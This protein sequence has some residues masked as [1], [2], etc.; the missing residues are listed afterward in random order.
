M[1][2]F[3]FGGSAAAEGEKPVQTAAPETPSGVEALRN[4]VLATGDNQGRPFVIVDKVGAQ[5][6]AFDPAGVMLASTPVLLGLAQGDDSPAG[7]GDR[8][9]ASIGPEERITPAGRFTGQ[10]G[11][12]FAGRTVLWVDYDAAIS[13]HPVATAVISEHRQA[14]LD[15]P[16]TSDNRISYGCINVP[17][18]F[19]SAVILPLFKDAPGLV[20]VLPELRSLD[21]Q[22]FHR[23]AS[24][25]RQTAQ[26]DGSIN[27]GAEP[28]SSGPDKE[29]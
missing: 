4:W 20:Y 24:R 22:F 15:S 8:A 9:L 3:G 18:A 29:W 25:D 17:A 16:M 11:E 26:V 28:V 19:Y 1:A 5:A 27:L 10:L 2:A 21:D 6:Q 7:I 23:A 14:R 12:N 13:L